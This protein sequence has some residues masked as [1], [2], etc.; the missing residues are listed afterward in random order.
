MTRYFKRFN[1]NLTMSFRVIDK[2][3]LENYNRAWEKIEELMR[4]DFESMPVCGDDDKYINTKIKTYEK[5]IT[6]NFHNKKAP[7]ERV[8]CKCISIIMLDSIIKANKK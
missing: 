4:V 6:I 2:Q 3:L 7:K 5:N 1:D 8:P